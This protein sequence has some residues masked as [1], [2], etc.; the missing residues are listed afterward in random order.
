MFFL[1]VCLFTS[2]WPC[3]VL[4]QAALLGEGGPGVDLILGAVGQSGRKGPA[5]P[6]KLPGC[7]PGCAEEEGAA[8]THEGS[9]GEQV[10]VWLGS[11]ERGNVAVCPDDCC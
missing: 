10:S 11:L 4:R 7:Q 6:A 5:A 2:L 1:F 8:P 9:T 3:S